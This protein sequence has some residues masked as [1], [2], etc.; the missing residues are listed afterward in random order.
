M[1]EA[2]ALHRVV[3]LARAV[4]SDHHH[5][6]LGGFQRADLRDRDLP[7]R[8]HFQQVGLE[9]L[10]GAVQLVDQQHR[11]RALPAFQRARER[12]LDQE[13]LGKNVLRDFFLRFFARRFREADLDHL[14]RV[15]PLVGRL[16]DVQ[17]LV[18]LQPDQLAAESG[19]DH[20]GQLGLADPRFALEKQRP[21]HRQAEIKRRGEAAVGHVIG[22]A[23]QLVRLVDGF[24][25]WARHILVAVRKTSIFRHLAFHRHRQLAM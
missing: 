23:E 17:A 22:L 9:R 15:V 20:L 21:L 4:G 8:E 14:A 18:A 24:W 1:V 12:T 25:E 16:G 13:L 3:D 7:V 5:R 2:A 11:R 10:V 6:G 19:G